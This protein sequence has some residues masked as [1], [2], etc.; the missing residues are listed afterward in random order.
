[1]EILISHP[2]VYVP[3]IFSDLPNTSGSHNVTFPKKKPEN[4]SACKVNHPLRVLTKKLCKLVSGQFIVRALLKY[5]LHRL[6]TNFKSEKVCKPL[7]WQLF[8]TNYSKQS[9]PENYRKG[10]DK[11][12]EH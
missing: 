4:T 2:T 7:P 6:F 3:L 1:M 12:R 5:W 8:K 11:S 10:S 9:M